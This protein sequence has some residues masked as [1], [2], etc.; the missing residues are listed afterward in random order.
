M[1]VKNNKKDLSMAI[2]RCQAFLYMLEME[3]IGIRKSRKQCREDMFNL[4][5][6]YG[7]LELIKKQ[8]NLLKKLIAI[9]KKK[10]NCKLS[11]RKFTHRL[12][13]LKYNEVR[14]KT[15]H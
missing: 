4:D 8:G 5:T 15:K 9:G 14:S 3:T 13:T 6:T 12:N 1:I 2:L 11:I 7:K 10:A